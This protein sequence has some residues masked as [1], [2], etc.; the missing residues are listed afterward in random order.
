MDGR[1]LDEQEFQNLS[2]S[3]MIVREDYI[4]NTNTDRM[5]S[6]HKKE[7]NIKL[8]SESQRGRVR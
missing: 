6:T 5:C 1:K 2:P 8:L 3:P 7:R 4:R